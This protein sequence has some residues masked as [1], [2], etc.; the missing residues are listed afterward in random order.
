MRAE[1]VL[2]PGPVEWNALAGANFKD[3]AVGL[4]GL[5][6]TLGAALAPA[7]ARKCDAEVV[8]RR[9]PLERNALAGAN[10]KGD[11]VGL[12]GLFQTLGAAL[13]LAQGRKCGAEV[14]LRRGPVERNALA[15]ANLKGGAVGQHGLFQA[16]GAALALAQGLKCDAEVILRRGPLE[17]NALAGV[18]L[19]GGAVGQHGLFQVRGAALALTQGRKCVAECGVQGSAVFRIADCRNLQQTGQLLRGI[20]QS[21]LQYLTAHF[22]IRERSHRHQCRGGELAAKVLVEVRAERYVFQPVSLVSAIERAFARTWHKPQAQAFTGRLDQA[23]DRQVGV[24]LFHY[25]ES[26]LLHGRKPIVPSTE[27]RNA[28]SRADQFDPLGTREGTRDGFPIF[29]VIIVL[30]PT[31]DDAKTVF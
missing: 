28:S 17:R 31:Q 29:S 4:H 6:Q 1:V 18:N 3:G 25:R 12:H 9:G 13:A 15:G 2:R 19:K 11:A 10:L 27:S 26:T 21:F 8:L 7:Q 14:V 5:F 30:Q 20:L 16:L 23:D 22:S 24:P